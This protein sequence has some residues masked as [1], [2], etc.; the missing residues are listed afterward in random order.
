M[1]KAVLRAAGTEASRCSSNS[2]KSNSN[3]KRGQYSYKAAYRV[4]AVR[5]VRAHPYY[6]RRKACKFAVARGRRSNTTAAEQVCIMVDTVKITDQ[7]ECKQRR[8][9]MAV[10]Y[11]HLTLPTICSV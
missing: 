9:T 10:S 11:T 5:R 7:V 6:Y 8:N 4:A 1:C 2:S 3:N